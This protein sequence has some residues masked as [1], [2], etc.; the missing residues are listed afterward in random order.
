MYTEADSFI[1]IV[2]AGYLVSALIAGAGWLLERMS[3]HHAVRGDGHDAH[4][5]QS[6]GSERTLTRPRLTRMLI[7]G[8][9][10][11]PHAD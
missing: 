2:V 4:R 1:V 8:G 9:K 5:G 10:E 7:T 3:E 6:S 11:E